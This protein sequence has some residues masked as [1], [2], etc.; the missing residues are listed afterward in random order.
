M[1]QLINIKNQEG[2]LTVSS[3]YK[4]RVN[5]MDKQ[6]LVRDMKTFVGGGAFITP[7]QIAKYMRLSPS[8]MPELLEALEYIKTGR[9][10]QY[11]I[12]DV[13]AR[14]LYEAEM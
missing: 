4:A 5:Q 13:V 14:I 10:R 6:T 2:K 3:R 8:R 9:G 11:F 7:T 12:P 1:K